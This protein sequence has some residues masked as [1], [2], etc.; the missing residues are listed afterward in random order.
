MRA[1]HA[2]A[3]R[4]AVRSVCDD[5]STGTIA[6]NRAY[7]IGKE[8]LAALGLHVFPETTT[9]ALGFDRAVLLSRC[10]AKLRDGDTSGAVP[11][12]TA[13]KVSPPSVDCPGLRA[14][15]STNCAS[16]PKAE[17]S[18]DEVAELPGRMCFPFFFVH[19]ATD[20][21]LEA[22]SSL[23]VAMRTSLGVLG[24]LLHNAHVAR[25]RMWLRGR[26]VQPLVPERRDRP[27]GL[28][29]PHASFGLLVDGKRWE[30]W[31]MFRPV[32][33]RGTYVSGHTWGEGGGTTLTAGRNS[34]LGA[35]DGCIRSWSRRGG[36]QR[37]GRR[38]A[39]VA[40]RGVHKPHRGE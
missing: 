35:A 12:G 39:D 16:E 18:S 23:F 33:G 19:D 2:Q 31:A 21:A 26:H 6:Y 34:A 25:T 9:T 15:H 36:Q 10:K 28:L 4:D 37:L 7:R 20:M 22:K 29:G 32:S 3:P 8:T 30:L 14:C 13:P 11:A 1:P 38:G 17:T 40:R 5:G 27:Y 24:S